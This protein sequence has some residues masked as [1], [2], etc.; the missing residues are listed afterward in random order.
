MAPVASDQFEIAEQVAAAGAGVVSDRIRDAYDTITAGTGYRSAA[1]RIRDEI[2][3]MPTPAAVVD[4]LAGS[5]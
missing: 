1:G 4:R 5:L 3:A 2:L